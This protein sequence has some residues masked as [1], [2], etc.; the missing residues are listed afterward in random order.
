MNATIKIIHEYDQ[1]PDISYM[2]TL[3]Q[4]TGEI[5]RPVSDLPYLYQRDFRGQWVYF[6]SQ[7]PI[8]ETYKDLQKRGYSKHESHTLARQYA[9]EDY[10]RLIGLYQGDWYFIGITAEVYV[11]DRMISTDSIWGV[12]CNSYIT[13][14]VSDIEQAV[15]SEALYRANDWLKSVNAEP[16]DHYEI[17]REK[18]LD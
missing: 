4:D 18:M 2:G 12:E 15:I 16:I 17:E 3:S 13:P 10:H 9:L 6:T 14:D 8:A 7:Q 1:Y 5:K 11:N